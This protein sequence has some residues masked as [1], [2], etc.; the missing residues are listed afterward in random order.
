[1]YR[2]AAVALVALALTFPAAAQEVYV[3]DPG[4][5]MASFETGRLGISWV[6]G[7][8]NKTTTARVVLDR[9][10]RK[11]NIDV[12]IDAASI[13]TGHAVRDQHLRSGDYFDVEKFPAITFKSNS[14]RFEGDSLVAATGDLTI[15]GV[16]KPVTLSVTLFRCIQHPVN[17]KDIC[18]ADASTAIKRSEFGMKLSAVGIADDVKISIQIEAYKD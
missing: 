1:M 13:D 5:T 11:G 6:R 7:R 4:H 8:F 16:T 10:A 14:L 9:A 17:K 12:V 2:K 18:G 3:G 15:M